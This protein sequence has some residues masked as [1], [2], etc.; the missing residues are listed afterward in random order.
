LTLVGE[1][2]P[3]DCN[4]R[5]VEGLVEEC[6]ALGLCSRSACGYKRDKVL[7]VAL[8]MPHSDILRGTCGSLEPLAAFRVVGTVDARH[9]LQQ[10]VDEVFG[11]STT[12]EP[13][14]LDQFLPDSVEVWLVEL[15]TVVCSRSRIT[16]LAGLGFLLRLPFHHAAVGGHRPSMSRC[17][18]RAAR[19]PSLASLQ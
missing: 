5:L 14:R 2:V 4:R 19:R 11:Q 9:A 7:Q 3:A 16:F 10:L 8:E 13:P 6:P 15:A 1:G 12:A 17:E 18:R